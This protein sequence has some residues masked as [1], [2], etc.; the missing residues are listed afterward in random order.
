[1]LLSPTVAK[2]LSCWNAYTKPEHFKFPQLLSNQ[3]NSIPACK[4]KKINSN[5]ILYIRLQ[6]YT[7]INIMQNHYCTF[8][9]ATI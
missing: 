4:N 6:S 8:C 2:P 7:D 1:M 3:S 5:R 9:Y